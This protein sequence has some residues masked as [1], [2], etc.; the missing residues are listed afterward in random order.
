MDNAGTNIRRETAF[1]KKYLQINFYIGIL[2]TA[3]CWFFA[4][5]FLK[6]LFICTIYLL[7]FSIRHDLSP[8][9]IT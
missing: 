7:L 9:E 8:C 1:Y 3:T 5:D 4:G 6:N 2:F